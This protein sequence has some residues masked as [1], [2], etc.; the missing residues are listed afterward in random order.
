MSIPVFQQTY[1]LLR[2]AL[3]SSLLN[4]GFHPQGLSN[5]SSLLGKGSYKS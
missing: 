3:I 1:A 4:W 2:S 5:L